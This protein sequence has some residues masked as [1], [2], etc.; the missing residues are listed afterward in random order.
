MLRSMVVAGQQPAARRVEVNRAGCARVVTFPLAQL[1]LLAAIDRAGPVV[2]AVVMNLEP[3]ITI[4]LAGT[5][6]ISS[7]VSLRSGWTM[8]I[9]RAQARDLAHNVAYFVLQLHRGRRCGAERREVRKKGSCSIVETYISG[10][11]P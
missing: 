3:L 9:V 11:L 5:R 6:P 4:G 7:A 1:A 2:T 8:R 10:T